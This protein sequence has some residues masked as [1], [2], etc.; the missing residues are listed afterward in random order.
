MSNDDDFLDATANLVPPLLDALEI[1]QYLARHMD[2]AQIADHL[3]GIGMPEVHSRRHCCH[4][5]PLP[6]PTIRPACTIT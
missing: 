6:G 5:E 1:L 2:P 4:F 3:A